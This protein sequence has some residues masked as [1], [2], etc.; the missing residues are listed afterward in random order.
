MERSVWPPAAPQS[1]ERSCGKSCPARLCGPPPASPDPCRNRKL[2]SG[3]AEAA[4][5]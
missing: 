1:I 4:K 5:F 2:A 3:S